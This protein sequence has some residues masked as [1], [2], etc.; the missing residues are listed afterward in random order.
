M[1]NTHY[2]F[3]PSLM[4]SNKTKSIVNKIRKE[5]SFCKGEGILKLMFEINPKKLF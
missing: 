1:I 3:K 5:R 2:N 4:K